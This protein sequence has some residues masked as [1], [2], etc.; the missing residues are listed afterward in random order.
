MKNNGFPSVQ[1]H[2]FRVSKITDMFAK[3]GDIEQCREFLG[4]KD[5]RTT[6]LYVKNFGRDK[7]K[8]RQEKAG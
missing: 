8:K 1:T 7:W 5:S 2:D 6:A 3:T 4:H